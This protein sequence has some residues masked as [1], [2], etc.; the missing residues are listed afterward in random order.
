MGVMSKT[1][2]IVTAASLIA[3]VFLFSVPVQLAR[4]DSI[5][6]TRA[7]DPTPDGCDSGVD[8]SLREAII[9]ANTNG[10][11]DAINFAIPT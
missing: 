8:C 10:V 5:I 6:V 1:L 11:P 7:D 4:A 2:R 9:A 3:A